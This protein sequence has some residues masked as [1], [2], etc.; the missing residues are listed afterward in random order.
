MGSVAV[1]I[2]PS[3]AIVVTS[4]PAAAQAPKVEVRRK[5]M[6]LEPVAKEIMAKGARMTADPM[7]TVTVRRFRASGGH[8]GHAKGYGGSKTA[9]VFSHSVRSFSNNR[10]HSVQRGSSRGLPKWTMVP[11]C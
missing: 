8:R 4:P 7:A 10:A 9:N 2:G 11:F 5:A 6:P 3:A 1:L